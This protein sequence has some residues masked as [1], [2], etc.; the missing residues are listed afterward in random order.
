MLF[1]LCCCGVALSKEP[2]D[3]IGPACSFKKATMPEAIQWFTSMRE[4]QR[5]NNNERNFQQHML[6]ILMATAVV[7]SCPQQKG[8]IRIYCMLYLS[9][10]ANYSARELWY[11]SS[12][13]RQGHQQWSLKKI[14]LVV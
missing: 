12:F 6:Y 14:Q 13:R 1:V 8:T 2:S 11:K 10:I 4:E 7:A 5:K 9:T 3:D